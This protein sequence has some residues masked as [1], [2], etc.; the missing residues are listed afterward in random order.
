MKGM[1]MP[2]CLLRLR[3]RKTVIAAEHIDFNG[4][5]PHHKIGLS[6][7]KGAGKGIHIGEDPRWNKRSNQ[8][9]DGHE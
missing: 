1:K 7:C 3:Y 4:V 6:R 8:Q 9:R 5:E 2:S